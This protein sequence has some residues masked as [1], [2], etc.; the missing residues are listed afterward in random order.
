MVSKTKF[1]YVLDRLH[2]H[3]TSVRIYNETGPPRFERCLDFFKRYSDARDS[4]GRDFLE[5]RYIFVF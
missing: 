2:V 3:M 5:M 4:S 1:L